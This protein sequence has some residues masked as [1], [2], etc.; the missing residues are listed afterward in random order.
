MKK[1]LLLFIACIAT[2]NLSAKVV[3]IYCFYADD[4][5]SVYEDQ[6]IRITISIKNGTPTLCVLNKTDDILYLDKG[7]CFQSKNGKAESLYTN[8]AYTTGTSHGRGASVN[9]GSLANA[10]GIGGRVGN[11]LNG[12][13][14]GGSTTDL[15]ST[16]IF[17]QRVIA[18]AP[19]TMYE[20]YVWSTAFYWRDIAQKLGNGK[21]IRPHRVGRSWNFDK[22]NS[23]IQ[24][25]ALI[26][27]AQKEDF[28]DAKKAFVSNY[29][30]AVRMGKKND[31]PA[32]FGEPNLCH[33]GYFMF[34]E[35]TPNGIWISIA[36]VVTASLIGG[37]V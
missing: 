20:I 7:N 6:S 3:S 15:N 29:I 10:I 24:L 1:I 9:V 14:V 21:S 22:N 19:K 18:L 16:T 12:L 11:A 37:C 33:R 34:R 36:T 35:G 4:Q 28:S 30:S 8:A 27:Y 23:P 31:V 13:T 17:E 25:E 5:Q 32:S 2:M 26:T